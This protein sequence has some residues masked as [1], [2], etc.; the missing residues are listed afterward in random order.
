MIV[1]TTKEMSF[2]RKDQNEQ[3]RDSPFHGHDG[4]SNCDFKG[5]V[6][7][8]TAFVLGCRIVVETVAAWLEIIIVVFGKIWYCVAE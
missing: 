4:N 1:F 5:F 2:E 6:L 8:A 3:N 7:F